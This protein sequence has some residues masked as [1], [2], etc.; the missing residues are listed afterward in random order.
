MGGAGEADA[1][2]TTCHQENLIFK[3]TTHW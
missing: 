2:A 1:A 3:F